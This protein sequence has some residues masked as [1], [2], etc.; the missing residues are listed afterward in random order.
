MGG[1][2]YFSCY[3]TNLTQ[4]A[5]TDGE[6]DHLDRWIESAEF[7]LANA[8]C[9]QD[10]PSDYQEIYGTTERIGVAL[11]EELRSIAKSR[12]RKTYVDPITGKRARVG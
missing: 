5:V 4:P 6:L 1:G 10:L 11:R 2:G 7:S 8:L 12:G 9:L 3:P